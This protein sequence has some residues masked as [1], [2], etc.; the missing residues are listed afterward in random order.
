[1]LA[2]HESN[3]TQSQPVS[4][5]KSKK[6]NSLPF[7]STTATASSSNDSQNLSLPLPSPN[8][9]QIRNSDETRFSTGKENKNDASNHVIITPVYVHSNGVNTEEAVVNTTRGKC[10]LLSQANT[11]FIILFLLYVLRTR[12]DENNLVRTVSSKILAQSKQTQIKRKQTFGDGGVSVVQ[13]PKYD[14]Y[15]THKQAFVSEYNIGTKN[16]VQ[17]RTEPESHKVNLLNSEDAIEGI[18]TFGLNL[19]IEGPTPSIFI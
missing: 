1:M 17:F 16:N 8:Q 3:L 14:D 12:N 19:K 2:V 13:K 6:E 10:L 15:V 9:Q 11:Q 4:V 7:T 18:N 5:L